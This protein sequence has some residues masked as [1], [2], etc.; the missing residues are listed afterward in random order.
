MEIK[1][2]MLKVQ[3][4]CKISHNPAYI[5]VE[6]KRDHKDLCI[7]IQPKQPI[8]KLYSFIILMDKIIIK[9]WPKPKTLSR[10][11]VAP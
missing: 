2:S 6:L 10:N 1:I 8:F 3:F 4:K 5:T 9:E 7:H 11:R